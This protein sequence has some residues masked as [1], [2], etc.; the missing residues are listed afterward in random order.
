MMSANRPA[1][2]R[3]HRYAAS[4]RPT[5]CP[6][7]GAAAPPPGG[8]GR[9]GT[10]R[11][12]RRICAAA[13][14]TRR[15]ASPRA[16]RRPCG[17]RCPGDRAPAASSSAPGRKPSPR[18]RSVVG[19]AQTTAPASP[20]SAIS[21]SVR[22]V[23]VHR[24][25]AR[26]P[27]RPHVRRAA[28]RA[29]RPYSARHASTSRAAPRTCMWSATS[30]PP[31]TARNSREPRPAAPRARCAAPRRRVTRGSPRSGLRERGRRREGTRPAS[32]VANRRCCG[33]ERPAESRPRVAHV[34]QRDAQAD[35]R[36]RADHLATPARSGPRSGVP[37]GWRC[38]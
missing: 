11:T 6:A 26:R 21:S 34:Q 10:A 18:S 29:G 28:P 16:G 17:C 14:D 1:S 19:Q 35:I 37:S 24:G 2:S 22:C 20:S 33:L 23:R 15:V 31:P 12:T 38:R 13:R 3:R 4:A 27:A 5:R 7:P 9:P 36:R 32:G 25:E 8:P 30:R